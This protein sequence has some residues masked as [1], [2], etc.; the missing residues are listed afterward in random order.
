MALSRKGFHGTNSTNLSSGVATQLTSAKDRNPSNPRRAK[1]YSMSDED[2]VYFTPQEETAWGYALDAH[3]AENYKTSPRPAVI[4]VEASDAESIDYD[5][6][7]YAK[8]GTHL[9]SDKPMDIT[10]VEW[11]PPP[12]MFGGT[13]TQVALPHI[14]WHQFNLPNWS[15]YKGDSPLYIDKANPHYNSLHHVIHQTRPGVLNRVR[16]RN[17]ENFIK[18]RQGQ[19]PTAKRD[20][21]EGQPTLF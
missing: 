3:T 7:W 8:D 20:P 11:G 19:V 4:K 2:K 17:K 15:V 10:G 21:M 13:A 9:V 12:G 6:N 1:R 18:S 14:N 16:T 5:K